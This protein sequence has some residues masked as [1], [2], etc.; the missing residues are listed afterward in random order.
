M[1]HRSGYIHPDKAQR[2]MDVVRGVP[3]HT[4][5]WK[6]PKRNLEWIES[7]AAGGGGLTLPPNV[8]VTSWISDLGAFLE[9]GRLQAFM[10]H[11]GYNGPMRAMMAGVPMLVLPVLGDQLGSAVRLERSGCARH[12]DLTGASVAANVA[13][14]RRFLTHDLES[15]RAS[16]RRAKALELSGGGVP[17]VASLVETWADTTTAG[18]VVETRSLWARLHVTLNLVIAACVVCLM[19]VLYGACR[20]MCWCGRR[21]CCRAGQAS[22]KDKVA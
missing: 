3:E 21:A 4:F 13:T 9:D 11:G 16:C 10:C 2:L 15:H 20:C 22:G 12:V 19:G 6:V 8:V 7:E 5:V 18:V 1:V 14:V 17:R